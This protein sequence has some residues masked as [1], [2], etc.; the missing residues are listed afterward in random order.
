MPGEFGN[1][2]VAGHRVSHNE[3]FR[4]LDRLEP[5]DEVIFNTATG[6]HTYHVLGTEVVGPDAVWIV[7]RTLPEPETLF[8]VPSSGIDSAAH[9][10]ASRTRS[11]VGSRSLSA[12][13]SWSRCRS[14]RGV[15]GRW[16]SSASPCSR[17]PA[18]DGTPVS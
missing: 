15:G 2:V 8:T 18:S 11:L 17:S 16:R 10:R 3:D 5:G 14:R 4:N 6:R 9:R 12:A 1:V 7:D 13:G